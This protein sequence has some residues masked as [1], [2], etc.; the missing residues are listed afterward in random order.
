MGLIMGKSRIA[1]VDSLHR[2]DGAQWSRSIEAV[3][4]C[5]REMNVVHIQPRSTSDRLRNCPQH[6]A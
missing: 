6:A 5:H 4:C 3:L 2:T 1:P